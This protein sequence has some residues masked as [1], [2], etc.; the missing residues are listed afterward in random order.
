[1]TKL[2]QK[3]IELG[4]KF[5]ANCSID[6]VKTYIKNVNEKVCHFIQV[7]DGKIMGVM[8]ELP[9]EMQK[10]LEELKKYE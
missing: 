10:D 9:N 6:N 1:M 8:S 2:E 7:L 5:V 4:Y 3:L